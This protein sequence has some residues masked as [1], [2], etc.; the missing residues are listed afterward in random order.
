MKHTH[1]A[2]ISEQNFGI[3]FINI[4]M[5]TCIDKSDIQSFDVPHESV[6]CLPLPKM[7]SLV[8]YNATKFVFEIK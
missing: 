2:I 4:S 5:P 7:P 8:L 6:Y 1:G 3:G